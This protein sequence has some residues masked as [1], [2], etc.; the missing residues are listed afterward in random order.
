M[1]PGGQPHLLRFLSAHL[2][3]WRLHSHPEL[4]VDRADSRRLIVFGAVPVASSYALVSRGRDL[5]T[6]MRLRRCYRRCDERRSRPRPQQGRR[7]GPCRMAPTSRTGR[8][9]GAP[10]TAM[11]AVPTLAVALLPI[12]Q[13]GPTLSVPL[14]PQAAVGSSAKD[15]DPA[16][17]PGHRTRVRSE[18]ES[19]R[20]YQVLPKPLREPPLPPDI[21]L[22]P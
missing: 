9:S 8:I 11:L 5:G 17:T 22:V 18:G 21:P 12:L 7:D 20:R 3:R 1:P 2:G 10:E 15:V 14:V 4:L 6:P 16:I 19:R 13:L